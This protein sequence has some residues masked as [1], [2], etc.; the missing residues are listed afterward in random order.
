MPA[1]LRRLLGWI[2][3][4]LALLCVLVGGCVA[5]YFHHVWAALRQ[6]AT[7]ERLQRARGAMGSEQ[8][9]GTGGGGDSSNNAG[10]GGTAPASA[11]RITG[12]SSDGTA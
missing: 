1:L 11:S 4:T 7:A 12:I 10:G 3:A 5:S 9:L 8:L 6:Q 2:E